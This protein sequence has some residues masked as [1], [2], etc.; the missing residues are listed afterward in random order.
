MSDFFIKPILDFPLAW[1]N[2][3]KPSLVSGIQ[4]VIA[5]L[6]IS[7]FSLLSA[8]LYALYAIHYLKGKTITHQP[9]STPAAKIIANIYTKTYPQTLPDTQKTWDY[10]QK[11][12]TYPIVTAT[13]VTPI[14]STKPFEDMQKKDTNKDFSKLSDDVLSDFPSTSS[15]I[16][17]KT[18]QL[19]QPEATSQK[20]KNKPP[21]VRTTENI[22]FAIESEKWSD[23]TSFLKEILIL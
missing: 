19:I 9:E 11:K 1:I 21:K 4:T 13:A 3:A 15:P 16:Q 22:F 23:I 17:Q 2:N 5:A 7:V 12:T 8:G 6:A 20:P 10:I 18:A 14:S